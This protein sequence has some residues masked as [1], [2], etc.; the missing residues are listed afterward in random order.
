MHVVNKIV[1]AATLVDPSNQ[2]LVGMDGRFTLAP[3]VNNTPMNFQLWSV[4]KY[5]RTCRVP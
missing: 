3:F 2:Y 4:I 5:V 1:Q